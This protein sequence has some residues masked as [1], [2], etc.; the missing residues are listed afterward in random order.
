MRRLALEGRSWPLHPF[1]PPIPII[2]ALFGMN[3]NLRGN[4]YS[5]H[6]RPFR[7]N[8]L[9]PSVV[10]MNAKRGDEA[11]VLPFLRVESSDVDVDFDAD[12][13]RLQEETLPWRLARL[14]R[15]C[16]RSEQTRQ[17]IIGSE[18]REF[19]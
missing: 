11:P 5:G 16:W 6:D 19:E 2:F 13:C 3:G 18:R 14:T 1:S 12:N 7:A 8:P 10:W 17:A 9:P 4:W 15:D